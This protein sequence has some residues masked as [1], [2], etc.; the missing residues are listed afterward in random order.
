MLKNGSAI[1]FHK[2]VCPD[3]HTVPKFKEWA[4]AKPKP[5]IRVFHTGKRTGYHLHWE[6]IFI[7]TH[8][9]PLYDE[10]LSWEGKMDKMT[11]VNCTAIVIRTPT[12]LVG[13]R[14]APSTKTIRK[15]RCWKHRITIL[16]FRV[17]RSLYRPRV[18]MTSFDFYDFSNGTFFYQP[19]IYYYLKHLKNH[20]VAKHD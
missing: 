11:Q 19:P 14:R 8:N 6:P 7:G 10:R 5:G 4:A 9:D 3:C 20:G 18:P 12:Q 1:T 15:I 13:R 2:K 17:C 16:S